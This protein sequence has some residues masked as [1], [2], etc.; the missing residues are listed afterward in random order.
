MFFGLFQN[1]YLKQTNKKPKASALMSVRGENVICSK[2]GELL[3]LPRTNLL[4]K[5]PI[6]SHSYPPSSFPL[7][8]ENFCAHS[9]F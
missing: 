5:I 3:R 2:S 7:C 8:Q 9:N 4:K 1:F 6:K